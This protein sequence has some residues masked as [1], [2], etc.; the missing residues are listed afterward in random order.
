GF[1]FAS[2]NNPAWRDDTE[3]TYSVRGRTLASLHEVANQYSG[4][5]IKAWLIIQPRSDGKLNAK[6]SEAEY[7]QVHSRLQDG[8]NTPIPDVEL[9]YK[10]FGLSKLPFQ[11]EMKNGVITDLVVDKSVSNWEANVIKSI[12]SQ[13][14]MN[15]NGGKLYKDSGNEERYV[16]NVMEETV[17]GNTETMY[18][19]HPIPEYTFQNAPLMSRL[20]KLKGN[21]DIFEVIKHKNYTKNLELPSYHYGLAG[22]GKWKPATNQMGKFFIRDS[23]SR[24]I[25]KGKLDRYTV[26]NSYT[27]NQIVMSPS[28]NDKQKGSVISLLNLT[29]QN[30]QSWNEKI[31]DVSNPVHL[32]GLV[33]TYD[34]PFSD[35]QEARARGS[36][37]A[38]W[39]TMGDDPIMT[40]HDEGLNRF[41]NRIPQE[42]S[43]DSSEENEQYYKQEKP[44]L[45]EVPAYP[46]LPY[47]TGNSGR[48]IR[49]NKNVNIKEIAKKTAQAI[50]MDLQD[51][52]L[53]LRR[54]SLSRFTILTSLVRLM[55]PEEL[56][57]VATDLYSQSSQGAYQRDAWNAYRDA[58]A[59]SGTGPAFIAI[60]E[61]IQTQKIKESEAATIVSTMT[62][63]VR[64][65]TDEY[66]QS[67]FDFI[68]KPEVQLQSSLNETALLAYT[69]LIRRVY[70]DSKQSK[71][72]YPVNSFGSFRTTKGRDMVK[73]KVIPYLTEQLNNAIS[74]ANTQKIHAYIRALGNTADPQIL[75]AFEPYI[76]GKKQASQFQRLLMVVAMDKLAETYP[77]VAREVLFNVYQNAG[78]TPEVRIAAVYQ[79]MRTNPPT[80]LLQRMAIYTNFDNQE[81]VNA[82]VKSSIES[83]ADLEGA[84][85][86]N[87]RSNAEAARPLLTKTK[88]GLEHGGSLLRNYV[89][90]ELNVDFKEAFQSIGHDDDM[91]PISLKYSLRANVGGAKGKLFGVQALLSSIHEL[92]HVGKL[93][94]DS[95]QKQMEKQWQNAD[96]QEKQ[97]YT[98]QNIAKLLN[99][100]ADEREQLEGFLNIELDEH[101]QHMLSLDNRTLEQIPEVIR[102]FEEQLQNGKELRYTKLTNSREMAISFPTEM[103]LPFL[104]TLDTPAYYKVEGSFKSVATP[105]VSKDNR[106]YKPDRLSVES[107]MTVTANVK[108]QSRLSFSA[109]FDNQQYVSG[110]DR[111]WQV[112][113][114][115]KGKFE[116]DLKNNRFKAEFEPEQKKHGDLL[117]HYST[118]PYTSRKDIIDFEPISLNE[119]TYYL[120]QPNMRSYDRVFG[121]KDIGMALHVQIKHERH[122][123]TL[124][125]IRDILQKR[126]LLGALSHFWD[127]SSIQRSELNV[128]FHPETSVRKFVFRMGY[129]QKYKP[130]L[131]RDDTANYESET[132]QNQDALIKKLSS[133]VRSAEVYVGDMSFEVEGEKKVKLLFNG[134]YAKSNVDAKSRVLMH[135]KKSFDNQDIKPFEMS[136]DVKSIIPN[137]NALDLKYSMDNEPK[138]DSQFQFTFGPNQQTSA[139]IKGQIKLRR[140]EERKQYLKEQTIFKQCEREMSEGNYHLSACANATMTANLLD[141]VKI[142]I[143]HENL[144]PDVAEQIH[145]MYDAMRLNYYPTLQVNWNQGTGKLNQIDVESRF[146][147]DLAFASVSIKSSQEETKISNIAIGEWTRTLFVVHPVFHVKS[148]IMKE[149]RGLKTYRPYFVV[150]GTS[151][152]TFNNRTYPASIDDHWTVALQYVP[153]DAR[154]HSGP[155]SV[156]EQ[157]K[158]QTEN[159][160]VLV[161]QNSESKQ[162][163]DIKIIL[164]A[165]ETDYKVL[166]ITMTPQQTSGLKAK[167]T[168][169]G[170]DVH[171]D[172]KESQ[173]FGN[174]FVQIY[175]IP[176]G[177]VKVEIRD[178][179]YVIY[180]GRRMKLTD[181][182]NKL[183]GS[184]RGLS[185]SYQDNKAEDFLLPENCIVSDY[186][187]FINS[188]DTDSNKQQHMKQSTQWGTCLRKD[189]PL[190]TNVIVRQDILNALSSTSSSRFECTTSQTRYSDQGGEICFTIRE[191][192]KCSS[193]CRQRSSITKKV[194][195]HCVENSRVAYLWKNQIDKGHSPDFSH[196]KETKTVDMEL[197][198]DCS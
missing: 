84:E 91:Y 18:D 130:G 190:Y 116:V 75:F 161:R 143:E 23:T 147:P 36:N 21:R 169:N 6:I 168:V 29:L 81:H 198:V 63:A 45:R 100:K 19:I 152:S 87:L 27:I 140:S 72:Q 57:Q 166:D 85:Y 105:R 9:S 99:L 41:G 34:N 40:Q 12:V 5:L 77:K 22:M 98:S 114:P 38:H 186:Q 135:F 178:V 31:G 93:Q 52:E 3:Y 193:H 65:P 133:G 134:G 92:I 43:W 191:L 33:Y 83:A 146:D 175:C 162:N 15:T 155:K 176:N 174:G 181:V 108:V 123:I 69:N 44:Q 117:L 68:R 106:L 90:D 185:G 165:P 73:N 119:N 62:R 150:D 180:D 82:A 74:F 102:I 145:A 192:P 153:K 79:F 80:E 54:D 94:T 120:E 109:P 148:R 67:F 196:K 113:L 61:W 71:N 56:K 96:K 144:R 197:P 183:R 154:H 182:S 172:D 184:V 28:L 59:E 187:Q 39:K 194:S 137:T 128:R 125:H 179:F 97:M 129:Q 95:Y 141:E 103:G 170:R 48:S 138:A 4:I 115:I 88:Y 158:F 118:W 60:Q 25:L 188:Y 171:V 195:V 127:D 112:H 16:F 167:V 47:T 37:S 160:V 8:W 17:T 156:Q 10:P 136:L 24:A 189:M 35:S 11:I 163:K 132:S 139:S 121:D 111:N 104:F 89:N 14:Q 26:E 177:E 131:N 124:S 173:D 55:T 46:L 110:Y 51:H 70:S 76:E 58:V 13:L 101:V 7:A 157:L 2:N 20:L 66:M 32:G 142:N 50:G 49:Q 30:S 107:T 164:S 1:A 126:G 151:I 42:H 53:S 78:E 149:I 86:H 159:Y 64:V 122:S